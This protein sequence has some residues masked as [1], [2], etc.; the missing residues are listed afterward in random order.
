MVRSHFLS[1]CA[2]FVLLE[3]AIAK[4]HYKNTCWTVTLE[5][6]IRALSVEKYFTTKKTDKIMKKIN[7]KIDAG[8]NTKKNMPKSWKMYPKPIPKS[9]KI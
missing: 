9:M 3:D 4:R 1:L 8:K 2:H 6:S 5:L 7:E